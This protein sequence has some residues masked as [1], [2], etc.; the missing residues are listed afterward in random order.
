MVTDRRARR[1]ARWGHP[2]PPHDWRYV[3]GTVGKVL[4]A[5]GLL[6]FGFVAYQLWGTGLEYSQAQNRLDD[7]LAELFAPPAEDQAPADL[8]PT[9]SPDAASPAITDPSAS[10][11]TTDPSAAPATSPPSTPAGTATTD[12]PV[13]PTVPVPAFAEGDALARIEI[14][15][16]GLDAVV[17][18]GVTPSDLKSG[19]GHYPDTPLPGQLGNSA[20]A[21][22][23]TTFGQPFFRLDEI[24]PGQEIVVTTVQGR[25]VYRMSANE[26]VGPGA[27]EVVSTTDPTVATLTLTTCDPKY[28]ATNRLVVYADLD[29]AAS[30]A[31]LPPVLDYGRPPAEDAATP[32]TL[33]GEATGDAASDGATATPTTGPSDEA[34]PGDTPETFPG[35]DP[36]V[37]STP[38][39]DS[40]P[41]G[42]E[43]GGAAGRGPNEGAVSDG[44][45]DAFSHGWFSDRGAFAQVAAWGIALTALAV[46]AYLVSRT[47]RRNWAGALVG[48]VPFVVALYFFFQ[49]VNRLLPAAL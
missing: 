7:E 29:T 22:H 8:P 1:D 21:G 38:A 44:S 18:A 19:P 37:S 47:L 17:V 49:N 41:G 36:T 33:P 25:F 2:P 6:M 35:D 42:A 39:T 12:P 4:I 13:S 20:I 14:P 23:R 16:I 30:G 9:T 40:E 15:S 26:I 32:A 46:G 10:P 5:T 11:A 24:A 48:V 34:V 3:V 28:T 45:A 31:G 27:G 43:P